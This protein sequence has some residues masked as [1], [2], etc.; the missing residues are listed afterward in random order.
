MRWH[1]LK[2][3]YD[4]EIHRQRSIILVGIVAII[5]SFLLS[6]SI[7]QRFAVQASSLEI[8]INQFLQYFLLMF[9]IFFG[10]TISLLYITELKSDESRG[11][12]DTF[13]T[14]PIGRGDFA[15]AKLLALSYYTSLVV[16]F[17][18]MVFLIFSG[19]IFVLGLWLSIGFLISILIL[20]LCVLSVSFVASTF[21]RFSPLS[22]M[23]I[24]LY[25]IGSYLFVSSIGILPDANKYIA[26]IFPFI[27]MEKIF[28]GLTISTIETIFM[29]VSIFV[30]I[31]AIYLSYVWMN[32]YKR[33]ALG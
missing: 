7:Q 12:V 18:T 32:T 1:K 21:A 15:F 3:L 2:I 13:L 27:T 14:H 19:E 31:G 6:F 28:T 16:L 10:A 33:R 4:I 5:Q 11:V 26:I 22:E 23:F 20:I 25:Y 29:G 30:Y 8:T 24:I 9:F 17:I